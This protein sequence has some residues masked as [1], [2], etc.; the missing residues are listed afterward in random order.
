MRR[1]NDYNFWMLEDYSSEGSDSFE[2]I[3]FGSGISL[4]TLEPL[5]R[6][7][8]ALEGIINEILPL[9]EMARRAENKKIRGNQ[10]TIEEDMINAL[11]GD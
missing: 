3:K 7:D 5:F 4:N 8:K 1:G 11:I 2:D 10:T 6:E 9:I